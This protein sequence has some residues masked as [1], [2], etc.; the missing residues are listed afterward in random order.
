MRYL[1]AVCLAS[2]IGASLFAAR[3]ADAGASGM[4]CHE[5]PRI[6]CGAGADR[7]CICPS[8]QSSDRDCRWLCG[9]VDGAFH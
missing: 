6:V 7:L 8:R 2:L 4:R 5:K 1:F 9:V 3:S